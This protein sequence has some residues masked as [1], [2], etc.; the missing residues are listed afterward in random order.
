VDLDATVATTV[1]KICCMPAVAWLVFS[2]LDVPPRTF[3][4]GV[5]M[6]AMPTAVST[7]VYAGELGGD[8]QFASTN[9]FATTV[10]S[11]GSLFILLSVVG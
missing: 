3:V 6:L 9:V 1:L 8:Q 5:T 10:A 7:F 4:A 11:V 2:A